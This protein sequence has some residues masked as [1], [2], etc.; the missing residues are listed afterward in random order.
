MLRSI[1]FGT[2]D[3]SVRAK[4]LAQEKVDVVEQTSHTKRICDQCRRS[5]LANWGRSAPAVAW[6]NGILSVKV[7]HAIRKLAKSYPNYASAIAYVNRAFLMRMATARVTTNIVSSAKQIIARDII[8]ALDKTYRGVSFEGLPATLAEQVKFRVRYGSL[9][10][11]EREDGESDSEADLSSTSRPSK[12]RKGRKKTPHPTSFP[13]LSALPP[14]GKKTATRIYKLKQVREVELRD[15]RISNFEPSKGKKHLAPSSGFTRGRT[16]ELPCS[17]CAKI[18][19]RG[20]FKRCIV[21]DNEFGGACC[22]CQYDAKATKCTF[23][24]PPAPPSPDTPDA[25]RT[26]QAVLPDTATEAASRI[27]DLPYRREVEMRDG[28]T[29]LLGKEDWRSGN[30]RSKAR[31]EKNSYEVALAYTKGSEVDEPCIRCIKGSGPFL[32][33]IVIDGE[34]NGACCNCRLNYKGPSCTFY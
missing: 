1:K 9:G 7:L 11:L 22:N 29:L 30:A 17:S 2:I 18:R 19:P 23:Y 26:K 15:N 27:Y 28:K 13:Q 34:F 33:C 31:L 12:K 10:V 24:H 25:T 3:V 5:V 4:T 21:V 8:A 16:P 20:P 14:T 32:R 6:V